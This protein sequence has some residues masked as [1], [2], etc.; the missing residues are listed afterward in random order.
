M[1]LCSGQSLDWLSDPVSP[2]GAPVRMV[3]Q[4]TV[5]Q[6]SGKGGTD[7]DGE[8]RGRWKYDAR[9]ENTWPRVPA[10]RQTIELNSKTRPDLVV[11]RSHRSVG[12]NVH[13]G[14]PSLE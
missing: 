12:T 2:C 1:S 10:D 4:E 6:V 11:S 3:E 8:I 7:Q 13:F 9:S 5:N 14:Y